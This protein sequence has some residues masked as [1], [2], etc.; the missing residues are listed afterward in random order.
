VSTIIVLGSSSPA[1][2]SSPVVFAAE[3]AAQ[4]RDQVCPVI[5]ASA[6]LHREIQPTP[7]G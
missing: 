2:S 5:G 6:A 7:G 3:N 4:H 1:V